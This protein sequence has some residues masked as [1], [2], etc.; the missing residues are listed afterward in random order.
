[1][2]E[3]RAAGRIQARK[4]SDGYLVAFDHGEFG[5][6]LWWYDAT[7][8]SRQR[9]WDA[10]VVGFV[11]IELP[12]RR[13][14]AG[15]AEGLDHLGHDEGRLAVVERG[16]S[17][18]IEVRKL[19]DL[20]SAPRVVGPS[21]AAGAVVATGDG[22]IRIDRRGVVQ[23][24]ASVDMRELYPQSI[25]ETSGLILVGMRRYLIEIDPQVRPP[26]ISWFTDASCRTFRPVGPASCECR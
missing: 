11:E 13:V 8:E 4:I 21:N 7:G 16:A 24:L 17:G 18:A 26:R 3:V 1:M 20:T 14:L 5:G 19:Q 9:L 23:N 6:S 25:V 22:V 12:G 2:P 10:H 15:V